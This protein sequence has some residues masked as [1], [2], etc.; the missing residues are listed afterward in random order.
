MRENMKPAADIFS[1]NFK[2]FEELV[3]LQRN[4]EGDDRLEGSG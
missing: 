4:R 1:V 3:K 2:S